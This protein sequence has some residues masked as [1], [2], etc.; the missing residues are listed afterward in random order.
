MNASS[1]SAFVSSVCIPALQPD[2]FALKM[3]EEIIR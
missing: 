3:T 1:P 2:E